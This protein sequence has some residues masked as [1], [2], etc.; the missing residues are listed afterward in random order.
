MSGDK[1]NNGDINITRRIKKINNIASEFIKDHI[2]ISHATRFYHNEKRVFYKKQ[3]AY[4]YSNRHGRL[5]I[6][7]VD[8][9]TENASK[10][11]VV[12]G[13]SKWW[14][15][16]GS[17]DAAKRYAYEVVLPDTPC[18]LYIDLEAEFSANP[19][20]KGKYVEILFCELLA[21][22]KL[23]LEAMHV[24]SKEVLEKMR[25]VV[26]DSSKSTKFSKHC[27]VKIPGVMF[28]NNYYCGAF[29]RRFQIHILNKYGP[30]E[31]N[32]YFVYPENL[33]K[34]DPK[35]RHFLIDLAVYTKGRDFRLLGSYKRAGT[36]D[37]NSTKR[38]LWIHNKPGLLTDVDFFDTLIQFQPKPAEVSKYVCHITDSINGGIVSS[39]SLRT[40]A[41]ISGNSVVSMYDSSSISKRRRTSSGKNS[42]KVE[43]PTEIVNRIWRMIESK[44]GVVI[45]DCKTL[46]KCLI[47]HT[48]SHECRIKAKVTKS[49]NRTLAHSKNVIY[50]VASGSTGIVNQKCFNQTYCFDIDKGEHLS[51]K[52]F[53]IR[54]LDI[55]RGLMDWC[56]ANDWE[57]NGETEFSKNNWLGSNSSSS[58]EDEKE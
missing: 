26:L 45:T 28:E 11:Y 42:I 23:F 38:F 10:A 53:T 35:F 46:G 52:L 44:S 22:L 54:D 16:Y 13:Y 4:E 58:S 18:H 30:L 24:A 14:E 40:V 17:V 32:K 34:R 29:I 6:F 55:I 39:S 56:E 50:F 49:K 47:F 9:S 8:I 1:G 51:S 36:K 5:P 21:E 7:S 41:P 33:E 20:I 12:C 25:F 3:P 2:P 57:W 43:C 19:E 31:T 27:I 48:T 15:D 37:P